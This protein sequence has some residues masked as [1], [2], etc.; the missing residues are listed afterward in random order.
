MQIQ[1]TEAAGEFW[2][3]PNTEAELSVGHRIQ[4]FHIQPATDKSDE[5]RGHKMQGRCLP[6]PLFP[7]GLLL[8]T[9][10]VTTDN[11]RDYTSEAPKGR[12]IRVD[13][14]LRAGTTGRAGLAIIPER[15]PDPSGRLSCA[16]AK[17]RH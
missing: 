16:R 6:R 8:P 1:V 17:R 13:W 2:E 10:R 15:Y 9:M 12:P 14:P 11:A 5:V 7:S 3:E 4:T